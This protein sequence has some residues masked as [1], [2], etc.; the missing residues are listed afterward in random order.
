MPLSSELVETL[1]RMRR[2]P[3]LP[4]A[5]N[6]TV[7]TD[8]PDDVIDPDDSG[9]RLSVRVAEQNVEQIYRLP[10]LPSPLPSEM[11]SSFWTPLLFGKPGDA[12]SPQ[13]AR[14]ALML[15]EARL[16]ECQDS[17]QFI[18]RDPW[19]TVSVGDELTATVGA[20]HDRIEQLY[21]SRGWRVFQALYHEAAGLRPRRKTSSSVDAVTTGD[22]VP[23]APVDCSSAIEPGLAEAVMQAPTRV[24]RWMLAPPPPDA[25]RWRTSSP[26]SGMDDGAWCG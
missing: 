16:G 19:A 22:A 12:V 13:N 24:Q 15:I 1:A 25:P 3:P 11:P 23:A 6:D 14:L 17:G 5:H 21:G 20:L 9:P 7:P 8:D 2:R 18:K 10:A 4:K 26:P